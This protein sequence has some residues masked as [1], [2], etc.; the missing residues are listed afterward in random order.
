[1]C[2][3]VWSAVIDP[4][5]RLALGAALRGAGNVLPIVLLSLGAAVFAVGWAPRLTGFLG[6]FPG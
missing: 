6:S 3:E 5:L 1:M 2:R 4:R